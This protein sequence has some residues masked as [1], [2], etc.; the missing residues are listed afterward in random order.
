MI[1]SPRRNASSTLESTAENRSSS[2]LLLE[3]PMRTQITAGPSSPVNARIVT[4]SS[5]FVIKTAPVI[6]A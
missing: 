2:A 1:V 5:S 6:L 3:L 4:K